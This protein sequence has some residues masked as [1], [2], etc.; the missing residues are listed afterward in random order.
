MS[1]LPRARLD[2]HTHSRLSDGRLSP[3]GLLAAAAAGGLDVLAITDHDLPPALPAGPT[4]V[5]PRTVLVVHGVEIS[6]THQGRELHLLAWFP[7]EM[8]ESFRAFCVERARSRARRYAEA[9]ENMALAGMAEP[10]LEAVEGRRALT[11]WHLA[12]ALVEAGHAA[13]LSDAF[14]AWVGEHQPYVPEM[15]LQFVDAIAAVRAA[16]GFSSWAHPDPEQAA[17]W[18]GTFA[19]AG[20]HAL[21]AHRPSIGKGVRESLARLA[22]RHRLGVTGGSDWHGWQGELGHFAVPLRQVSE[23]ARG[24]GIA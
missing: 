13:T 1:L 12:K 18:T 9:L 8:P 21:E 17:I 11:R 6:A 2:L 14:K 7:G 4:R 24:V 23:L 22:F 15:D 16:G 20:L 19:A 10:D 5:G 3:E